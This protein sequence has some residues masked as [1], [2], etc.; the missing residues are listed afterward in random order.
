MISTRLKLKFHYEMHY[1][2]LLHH[3]KFPILKLKFLCI[4]FAEYKIRQALCIGPYYIITL[5]KSRS[6]MVIF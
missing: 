4:K 3:I 6:D 1:T 2:I 5:K